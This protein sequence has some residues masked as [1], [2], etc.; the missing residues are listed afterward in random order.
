MEK[1]EAI[2]QEE[3]AHFIY[4]FALMLWFFLEIMKHPVFLSFHFFYIHYP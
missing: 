1:I 4:N 3:R 2:T